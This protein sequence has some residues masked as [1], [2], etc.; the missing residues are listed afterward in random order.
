V[1]HESQL[2]AVAA[3]VAAGQVIGERT[4]LA[5]AQQAIRED[6]EAR[7][8]RAHSNQAVMDKIGQALGVQQ[9]GTED[10]EFSGLFNP[11]DPLGHDDVSR[12]PLVYDGDS[13]GQRNR[14]PRASAWPPLTDDQ[15]HAVLFGN[16]TYEPGGWPGD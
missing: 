5:L 11:A 8:V 6:A 2:A 7:R 12:P 16:T 10:D 15:L 9:L 3:A 13:Q 14:K 1:P 4:A